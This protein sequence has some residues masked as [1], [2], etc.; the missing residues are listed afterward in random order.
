MKTSIGV[1][2]LVLAVGGG[3]AFSQGQDPKVDL[4]K[5][6]EVLETDL[7]STR[8]KAEALATELADT[9]ASV[10]KI[11]Q[12]LEAQ[13]RSAAAMATALDESEQAGFTAGINPNSRTILL[14]GWRVQLTTLQT[15]VPTVVKKADA[16]KSADGKKPK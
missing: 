3:L 13:A 7:I 10:A 2:L 1:I 14:N 4:A 5:K 9:K 8:A 15:D 11:T 12:Y 16:P 6:V